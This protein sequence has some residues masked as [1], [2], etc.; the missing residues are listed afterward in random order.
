MIAIVIGAL[1]TVLKG[2]GRVENRR[3]TCGNPKN[4]SLFKTGQ[5]TEKS[6]GDLRRCAVS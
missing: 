4:S 1:G 3:S 2:S 6:P 5:I